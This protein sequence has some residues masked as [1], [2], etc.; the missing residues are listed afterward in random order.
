MSG[1]SSQTQFNAAEAYKSG[2]DTLI[3]PG[4]T[5]WSVNHRFQDVGVPIRLQGYETKEIIVEVTAGS[6][7]ARSC[8]PVSAIGAGSVVAAGAVVNRSCEAGSILA[9]VPAKV[10]GSRGVAKVPGSPWGQARRSLAEPGLAW[11]VLVL[12]SLT[13]RHPAK[14]VACSPSARRRRA[15]SV[16]NCA[17][18]GR[19]QQAGH[20]ML[21]A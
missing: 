14:S 9:G 3:G 11:N 21:P 1:I 2:T 7:A 13:E 20:W 5:F 6:P 12:P 17:G 4:C 16:V 10:I 18:N 19:S 8:C 15:A